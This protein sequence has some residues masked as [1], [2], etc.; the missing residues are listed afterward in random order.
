MADTVR[1]MIQLRST[2][3]LAAAAFGP[4]ASAPPLG[5]RGL[6]GVQFDASYSPVPIPPR[7]DP[8]AV[9]HRAGGFVE[10]FSAGQPATYVVRAAVEPD[11]LEDF[12]EKARNDPSVVQ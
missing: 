10:A 9:T 5:I 12:L 4:V 7:P 6:S 8:G 1:V 11:A 2:P 3:A